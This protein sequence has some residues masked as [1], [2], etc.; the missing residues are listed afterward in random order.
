M[1]SITLHG[2]KRL[3]ERGI[4]PMHYTCK[5]INKF[6]M[7]QLNQTWHEQKGKNKIVTKNNAIL[8]MKGQRIITGYWNRRLA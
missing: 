7:S 5:D 3:K 4:V 6:I 2:L 8:V 1:Y